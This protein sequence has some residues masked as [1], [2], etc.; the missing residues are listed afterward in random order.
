M[1]H[2][3]FSIQYVDTLENDIEVRECTALQV[4]EFWNVVDKDIRLKWPLSRFAML[5][6]LL[7]DALAPTTNSFFAM[8]SEVT[9]CTPRYF[10]KCGSCQRHGPRRPNG[11]DWLPLYTLRTPATSHII[12]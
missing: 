12:R 2:A 5:L 10:T 11:L 7:S 9:T 3:L 1:V 6:G 8:L 4:P